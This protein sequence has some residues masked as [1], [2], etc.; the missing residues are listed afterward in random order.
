MAV[1]RFL[2]IFPSASSLQTDHQYKMAHLSPP[3]SPLAANPLQPFVFPTAAALTPELAS[4]MMQ[5]AAALNSALGQK[6]S[7][8]RG[9][10]NLLYNPLLYPG[11]FWP[12]FLLPNQLQPLNTKATAEDSRNYT[13]TPEKEDLI[14]KYKIKSLLVLVLTPCVLPSFPKRTRTCP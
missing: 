7:N 8:N 12:P 11:M 9:L 5:R 4:E 1:T 6:W 10:T 3:P 13:L 2:T 14:G